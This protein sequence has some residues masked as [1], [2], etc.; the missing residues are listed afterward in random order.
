MKS[1]RINIKG[2]TKGVKEGDY[3]ET[4]SN[5]AVAVSRALKKFQ[6]EFSRIQFDDVVIKVNR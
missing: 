4:A 3:M 5:R 1:F 2:Y 6:K